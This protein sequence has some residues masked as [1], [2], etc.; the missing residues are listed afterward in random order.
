MVYIEHLANNK[1]NAHSFSRSSINATIAVL[2]V[3]NIN[4]TAGKTSNVAFIVCTLSA[5]SMTYLPHYRLN[6]QT[7]M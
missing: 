5:K 4:P 1:G 3:H 6:A 7:Q 2:L